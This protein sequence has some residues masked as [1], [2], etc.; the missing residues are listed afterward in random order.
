MSRILE[1]EPVIPA[2][3]EHWCLSCP[4]NRKKSDKKMY[5][6][7]GLKTKHGHKDMYFCKLSYLKMA[8]FMRQHFHDSNVFQHLSHRDQFRKARC[9]KFYTCISIDRRHS[10][11]EHIQE[12]SILAGF[13]C[14][15]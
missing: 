3:L 6:T 14:I 1:C 8:H 7:V 12:R 13:V 15:R 4:S 5:D 9:R 11:L 10:I 2:K